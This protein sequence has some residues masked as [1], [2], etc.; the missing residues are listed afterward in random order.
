MDIKYQDYSLFFK[1]I[2]TF[3]PVGFKGIDPD[4]PLLL[5]L[6]KIMEKNNQFINTADMIQ[7]KFLFTS[8]RSTQMIGVE[9][10]D[11]TPYHFFEAAHADD[12]QRFSI[13]RA[14]LI[15][16]AQDFYV[17]EKGFALL[18]TNIR[19]RNPQGKYSNL[20]YQLYIYYSTI[21]YKSVY[22]LKIHTNIDWCKK[23]K[24]GYHYYLGND[25][26]YFRYPD[27]KL[28]M[29]GNPFSNREF[30]IIKLIE[31]GLSSEQIAEKLFLSI[32]TVN[33][34]RA[35]ILK[36]SGKTTIPDVIY[37]LMKRGVL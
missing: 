9:P 19:T 22:L 15:K 36:K 32:N 30:E 37:D 26:S 11:V 21:P 10:A 18:S 6:E 24:N 16:L 12:N 8:K 17:A 23:L 20:L 28:L 1:F 3:A 29:T 7:L 25:M 14:R 2:E 31:V 34:H 35:N 4:D 27:D 13:G 33:A 5:E